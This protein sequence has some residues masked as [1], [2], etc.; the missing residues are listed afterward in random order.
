MDATRSYRLP[1]VPESHR[2]PIVTD[3]IPLSAV[4]V[5]TRPSTSNKRDWE[6]ALLHGMD[7]R[8]RNLRDDDAV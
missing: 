6:W 4:H 5:P 2:H 1:F 3:S 8:G 7:V